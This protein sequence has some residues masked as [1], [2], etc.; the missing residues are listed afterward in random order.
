MQGYISPLGEVAVIYIV[1]LRMCRGIRMVSTKM[2]SYGLK[3]ERKK[4]SINYK[5]TQL[6]CTQTTKIKT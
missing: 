2:L 5:H 3:K 1:V 4:L 6:A